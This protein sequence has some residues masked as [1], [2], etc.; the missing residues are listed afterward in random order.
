MIGLD[1]Q[2]VRIIKDGFK[3]LLYNLDGERKKPFPIYL[4]FVII[5]SILLGLSIGLKLS[6]SN[7][8]INLIV[9]V[10]GIFT[11]LIFG[12]LFIA[13]DKFNQRIIL[14]KDKIIDKP[15]KNYLKRFEFFAEIFVE[16]ISLIIVVS[17]FV[18]IILLLTNLINS[19][20]IKV[21]LSSVSFA[22]S[23]IFIML[24]FVLLSNIYILLKDDIRITARLNKK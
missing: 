4:W 18:I 3:S 22:L 10:L 17:I 24:L 7:D 8:S 15:T 19:A 5:P 2:I 1:L 11:A 20:I 21:I 13:P 6:I 9:T 23:F 16:Q 14:Y 12:S